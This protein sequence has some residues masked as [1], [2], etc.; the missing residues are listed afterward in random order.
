MCGAG[1]R[2]RA[3]PPW[4]LLSHQISPAPAGRAAH[5]SSSSSSPPPPPPP[6]PLRAPSILAASRPSPA[7]GA[8][9]R[10]GRPSRTP[11][12]HLRAPLRRR[13]PRPTRPQRGAYSRHP[14]TRQ[15]RAGPPPFL[16]PHAPSI[17]GTAPR[18]LPRPPAHLVGLFLS[19]MTMDRGRPCPAHKESR[20]GGG[21]AEGRGGREGDGAASEIGRAH[22]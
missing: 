22:V 4:L 13:S 18:P 9:A 16:P 6:P 2:V 1:V 5:T 12:L 8:E 3:E 11:S 10:P 7:P 14:R 21:R 19:P 20:E 17:L 15:R